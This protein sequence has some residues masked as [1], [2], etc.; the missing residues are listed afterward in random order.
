M[1]KQEFLRLLENEIIILDGATGTELQK[2]GMPSDVCPE[3]WVSRNPGAIK[4]V[5]Q[6]YMNAGSKIVYSCTLGANRAKLSKYGL[7]ER[8]VEL[9][10]VLAGIS[11]EVAGDQCLVAGDIGPTGRLIEP[12]GDM[13]FEECVQI[14]KEQVKGLIE[15]GVDLFVIETMMDIQEARAALIAVRE[16]C[17]LP[18]MVS[19]SYDKSGRTM[20][21]T[22]PVTALITLQSLGADAVG[23]N[24]STGPA[25]MLE[26]I[27]KIRPYAI[28]P[29]IAKPNAGLPR[30]VDG[31]TVFDMG[32]EEFGSFAEKFAKAGVSLLGGCC[33][34]TPEHI[35]RLR[36][37]SSGLKPLRTG[38]NA[39]GAVTSVS[40][41]TSISAAVSIGA[42]TSARRTVF[43]GEGFPEAAVGAEI[44]LSDEALDLAL[45]QVSDGADVICVGTNTPGNFDK[46]EAAELV[47]DLSSNIQAPICF[48]S[49]LPAETVEAVLRVYPGRAMVE[50][51]ADRPEKADGLLAAAL[52]YGSM[53]V[54]W[55]DGM[56]SGEMLL[57]KA[58]KF[59]IGKENVAVGGRYLKKI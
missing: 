3:E 29:L 54:I 56:G 22:D 41:A 48:A 18:V 58:A 53:I 52:K 16:S 47:A 2:R 32:A 24:C 44:G 30:L 55:Q 59:G 9:N 34:T 33:G 38:A 7:S 13:E 31:K 39:I 40:A 11:K 51:P 17:S 46:Q 12:M 10:R 49:S 35:S 37:Q 25:Q 20:M 6:E 4:E 36:K 21:G 15:G 57:E 8:V 5:Q 45:E 42:V 14:F 28:V 19:M 27:E 26:L 1:V 50:L 43:I 23:C